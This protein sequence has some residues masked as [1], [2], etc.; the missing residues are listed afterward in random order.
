M[1]TEIQKSKKTEIIV[2]KMYTMEKVKVT[3]EKVHMTKSKSNI[4][5]GERT[6]LKET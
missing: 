2:D 1:V 5:K 4:G 6:E 3:V